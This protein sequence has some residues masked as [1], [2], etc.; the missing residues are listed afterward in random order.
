MPPPYNVSHHPRDTEKPS[1]STSSFRS[2]PPFL[3][4]LRFIN[5]P[6]LTA[7]KTG[8]AFGRQESI[9]EA[10][11]LLTCLSPRVSSVVQAKAVC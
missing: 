7:S 3:P 9:S 8:Y 2:F 10:A 11:L 1:A 4:K 5:D 6:E